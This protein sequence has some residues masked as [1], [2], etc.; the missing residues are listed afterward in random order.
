MDN[1]LIR[2]CICYNFSDTDTD[3]IFDGYRIWIGYRMDINTNMDI[4]RILNKNIIYIIEKKLH[5]IL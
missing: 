5:N 1:A 4:F 3:R 2:I